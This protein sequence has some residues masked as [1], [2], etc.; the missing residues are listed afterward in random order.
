MTLYNSAGGSHEPSLVAT[1]GWKPLLKECNFTLKVGSVL[2]PR[3]IN[4]FV[5]LEKLLCIYYSIE[6]E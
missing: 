4:V 6:E 5:Y 2:C 1:T 3:S